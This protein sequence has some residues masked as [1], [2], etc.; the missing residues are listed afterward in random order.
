MNIQQ[1][2]GSG[3][4]IW[5]FAVT[6]VL[7]L[8]LTSAVWMAIVLYRD[9][10]QWHKQMKAPKE[11]ELVKRGRKYNF[12]IRTAILS[13]ILQKGYKRWLW[14]SGAWIRILTNERI[15]L[16]VQAKT[17]KSPFVNQYLAEFR[18]QAACDYVCEYIRGENPRFFFDP[19]YFYDGEKQP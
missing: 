3:Q 5:V 1:L 9:Y 17:S 7:A 2:N 18:D 19:N 8:L 13:L 16:R 6:A 14:K 11:V 12:V 10:C 4:H 15:K